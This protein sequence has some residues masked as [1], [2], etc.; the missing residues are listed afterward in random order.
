METD[1]SPVKLKR[2]TVTQ[3]ASELGLSVQHVN[4]VAK[5]NRV[6]SDTLIRAIERARKQQRRAKSRAA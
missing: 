6:G 2:G 3:I 1:E 5:G 4:E